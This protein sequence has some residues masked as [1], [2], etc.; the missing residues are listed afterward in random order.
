MEYS[1]RHSVPVFNVTQHISGV[2]ILESFLVLFGAGNLHSKSGAPHVQ[3]YDIKGYRNIIN[4]VI[5]FY[6][7]Y[8]LC[9]GAKI[10][11]FELASQIC[12][13]LQDGVHKDKDG[14]IKMVR[15]VYSVPGKG[16]WRK[17]TLEEVIAIIESNSQ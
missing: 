12:F 1:F 16:K 3:V 9:F 2:S 6:L 8:V 7:E 11:Q 5:P 4:L 13:M 10:P 15:L 14:L 17:R